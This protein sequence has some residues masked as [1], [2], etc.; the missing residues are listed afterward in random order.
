MCSA[1]AGYYVI[2]CLQPSLEPSVL[3]SHPRFLKDSPSQSDCFACL[4]QPPCPALLFPQC[5]KHAAQIV[6]GCRPIERHPLTGIG[7]VPEWKSTNGLGTRCFLPCWPSPRV[8]A[9]VKEESA[10]TRLMAQPDQR[11]RRRSFQGPPSA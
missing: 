5:P 11:V 1:S 6:L 8:G 3:L 10:G 7:L 4:F 2:D 9:R